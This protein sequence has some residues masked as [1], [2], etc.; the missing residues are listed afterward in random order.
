MQPLM[1]SA[2]LR[3]MPGACFL[4]RWS[5]K[6]KRGGDALSKS[7]LYWL[8]PRAR[9]RKAGVEDEEGDVQGDRGVSWYDRG[10]KRRD[11]GK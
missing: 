9:E 11:E 5:F 7:G 8:L 2:N 1:Q 3:D 4:A 10:I 6:I